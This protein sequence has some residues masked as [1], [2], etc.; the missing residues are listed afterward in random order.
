MGRGSATTP[1]RIA[2]RRR[3]FGPIRRADPPRLTPPVAWIASVRSFVRAE[4][5]STKGHSALR[6]RWGWT[7]SSM[8]SNMPEDGMRLNSH[9]DA[10]RRGREESMLARY[11]QFVVP[12]AIIAAGVLFYMENPWFF[13]A[14]GSTERQGAA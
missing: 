2:R 6:S 4:W 12:L 3:P 5:P 10:L 8:H 14:D 1:G 9:R 11:R 7:A 13:P